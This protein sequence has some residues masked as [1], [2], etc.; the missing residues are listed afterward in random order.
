MF[1][2]EE[3]DVWKIRMQAHLAEQGDDMCKKKEMKMEFCL[4]HDIVAKALCAKAGSFDM[5]SSEKFDLM[6]ATSVGLELEQPSSGEN[7]TQFEG[8]SINNEDHVNNHGSNPISEDNDTDHQVLRPSNFQMILYTGD[9]KEDTHI[10]FLEDSDYSQASAHQI[11]ISSPPASPHIGS[12]LE[13]SVD[14]RLGYMDSK[15]EQMLNP[16]SFM[17]HKIG[18]SSWLSW[19]ISS[20]RLVMPKMGKVAKV[21]VERGKDLEDKVKVQAVQE[22]KDQARAIEGVAFQSAQL[23]YLKNLQRKTQTKAAQKQGNKRGHTSVRRELI[24]QQ[25]IKH[26]IFQVMICM[27]VPKNIGNQG[28]QLSWQLKSQWILNTTHSQSAGGNHQSVI[29]R[30]DNQPIIKAQWYS[31]ATAQPASTSMIALDL[32]GVTTQQADH[33]AISIL[34]SIKFRLNMHAYYENKS[35]TPCC[36]TS[37][38]RTQPKLLVTTCSTIHLNSSKISSN[39][40]ELGDTNSTSSSQHLKHDN[41][42]LTKRKTLTKAYPEAQSELGKLSTGN[43]EDARTCNYFTLLQHVDLK[44]KTGINRRSIGRRTQ[45][46][47][48]C[49]KRWRKSTAISRNRVR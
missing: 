7:P 13:E 12:K 49:S 15:L 30:C 4:L 34:A 20:K 24:K 40:R 39:K 26:A 10:S 41:H 14:S 48:P 31:G 11:F 38:R 3:Y 19:L 1:S 2:K 16:Q 47:Q 29:F 22:E 18:T 42:L 9:S 37:S 46:H 23:D 25:F 44:L 43:R 8:P 6:V 28:Q 33:N 21:V 45:R 27:R 17:K 36:P 5:A 32:S 35:T